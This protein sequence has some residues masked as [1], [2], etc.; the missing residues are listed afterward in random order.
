MKALHTLLAAACFTSTA[1]AQIAL[2]QVYP[3]LGY[4]SNDG[5]LLMVDLEVAGI[6]YVAIDRSP[7]EIRFYDLSHT[8]FKTISYAA[9]PD[10]GNAMEYIMYISQHLFDLDDEVE[11]LYCQFLPPNLITQVINED[12]TVLLDAPGEFPF[13]V[14]TA[15]NQHY[16]VYSTPQ[17]AKL[18]L[19]A[20]NGT[21]KVYGLPGQFTT[22]LQQQ[23]SAMLN[24]GGASALAFPNPTTEQL[25][26]ELDAPLAKAALLTILDVRGAI[27]RQLPVLRGTERPVVDVRSLAPGIYHYRL[28]GEGAPA[29]TGSF[30]C[31]GQ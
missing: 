16:P 15:H 13:V 23:T 18:I 25:T 21:A 3:Q 1:H 4:F 7:K 10:F 31:G 26:L 20:N 12:G 5:Q 29:I 9:A 11:F 22:G 6:S 17:G 19:S 24:M 30:V 14:A 8:L 2:E 28:D 27:V